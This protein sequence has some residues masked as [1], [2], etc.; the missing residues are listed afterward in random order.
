MI[1]IIKPEKP[2]A[3]HKYQILPRGRE[4][5]DYDRTWGLLEGDDDE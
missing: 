5:V 4:W 3:R 2:T 1:K